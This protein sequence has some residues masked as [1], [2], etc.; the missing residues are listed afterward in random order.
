MIPDPSRRR[1]AMR[2]THVAGA[3]RMVETYRM[4]D[5]IC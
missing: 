4:F 1:A 2:D 5:V 3:M